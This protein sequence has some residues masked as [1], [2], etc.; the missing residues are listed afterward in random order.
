MP[1]IIA[2][3]EQWLQLGL[4]RFSEGGPGALVVE[5][6]AKALGTSKSSFYWHF[7]DRDGYLGAVLEYWATLGTEA[8]IAEAEPAPTAAER[9]HAVM[10]AALSSRR[11]GDFLFHLRQL[12]RADPRAAALLD[13]TE[14]LRLGYLAGLLR[15]MGHSAANADRVASVIY[16]HYLGWYE[17][18][19]HQQP[20]QQQVQAVIED[21]TSVC[22]AIGR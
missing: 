16:H 14:A 11:G 15:K 2:T 18:H 13:R 1:K 12:A 17:R 20:S 21:L 7:G 9:L 22:P 3:R 19:K 10:A 4:H 8:V 5:R 6:L